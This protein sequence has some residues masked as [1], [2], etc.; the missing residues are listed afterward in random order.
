MNDKTR[1]KVE[2]DRSFLSDKVKYVAGVD[3]VGRGP[4]AGPV[5]CCA[6]I[7]PLDDE[8]IIDG[9]D[10][11]KKVSAKKR[12]ALSEALRERAVAFS[13][14]VVESEEIDRINILEATKKCMKKCVEELPI[15]PDLVLIDAVKL[16][17]PVK[18]ASIIKGDATS[19]NVGAASII[20][21]VYRDALM[22]EYD[23]IY[24]GYG[25]S[26]NKGYGTKVH[27]D[28]LKEKGACPIHRKTFIKNFTADEA[29]I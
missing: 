14:C 25:F 24:P 16:D 3:E 13:V 20:A 11:S 2:N 29:K 12:E 23:S 21:K 9:V 15:T 17:L 26:K 7:M 18:T 5:A 8:S 6:V 22:D 1:A 28:A 10:D 4:L 27:I 19:Y